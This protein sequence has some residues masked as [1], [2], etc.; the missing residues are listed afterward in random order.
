[1]PKTL[2]LLVAVAALV[3]APALAQ[4]RTSN[5]GSAAVDRVWPWSGVWAVLL[6]KHVDSPEL[7]CEVYTGLRDEYTHEDYLWGWQDFK[8]ELA[9]FV[10][11]QAGRAVSG[12]DITIYIDNVKALAIKISTRSMLDMY[13][14]IV[15]AVPGDKKPPS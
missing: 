6:L 7:Q 4:Q 3:F 8:G 10:Y 1:M 15:A 12:S 13:N 9:F 5:T 2:S 14:T 11:D